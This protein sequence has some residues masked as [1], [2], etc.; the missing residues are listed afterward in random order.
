LWWK[1]LYKFGYLVGRDTTILNERFEIVCRGGFGILPYRI[2]GSHENLCV[3]TSW[4]V[5]CG[6]VGLSSGYGDL[7]LN[8]F[9]S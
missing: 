6:G 3:I 7:E 5:G 8:I 9:S 1:F 2:D 4:R